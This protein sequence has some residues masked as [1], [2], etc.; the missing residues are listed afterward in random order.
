MTLRIIRLTKPE[1]FAESERVQHSAWGLDAG[2]SAVPAHLLIAVQRHDGLVLGAYDGRRMV[3]VLMGFT[4]L[5]R[6]RP[7]HYSHI[8]GVR[9]DYQSRGVGYALKLGQREYVLRRGL[10]LVKW[11]FDPLQ[12]RNAFFNIAKLG[13]V[14]RT[15]IRNMY[16][17]LGDSLNRGRLTD[18]LEVEWWVGSKRV[19]KLLER[20]YRGLSPAELLDRGVEVVNETV[21]KDGVR[22]PSRVRLGLRGRRLLVEIPESIVKVR[23]VSLAASRAW[24]MSFRRIFESY[25]GRGYV[26]T[27]VLVES[28]SGGRRV[29][30]LLESGRSV[31]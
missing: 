9:R 6:G 21:K 3:G 13:G 19:R 27:D 31:R 26:V 23:D 2:S 18:R 14:C 11:T 30:Y 22:Q 8:T 17:E 12:A 16:G 1:Q 24:T 5:S 25:F 20:G 7:Y 4:A 10:S 15:Y 29:F 28:G